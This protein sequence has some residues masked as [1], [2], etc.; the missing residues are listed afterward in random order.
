M[1]SSQPQ[2]IPRDEKGCAE[3]PDAYRI[4]QPEKLEGE[5]VNPN[6]LRERLGSLSRRF[7]MPKPI[8]EVEAKDPIEELNRWIQD[9]VL[10]N[11]I[12]ARV[13]KSDD[14]TVEFDE[15]GVPIRV[16]KMKYE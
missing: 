8:Q 5:G 1:G 4:W 10:R 12:M 7:A 15:E 13:M 6:Q 9:P 2:D 3:N 14:L 11:E 16:M